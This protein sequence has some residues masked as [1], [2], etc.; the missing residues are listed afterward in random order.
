MHEHNTRPARLDGGLQIFAGLERWRGLR[1]LTHDHDTVGVRDGSRLA[2]DVGL[3]VLVN[4]LVPCA[5]L[6]AVAAAQIHLRGLAGWVLARFAPV[7]HDRDDRRDGSDHSRH[8]ANHSPGEGI[9]AVTIR[10]PPSKD[11][12]QRHNQANL[13]KAGSRVNQ[14]RWRLSFIRAIQTSSMPVMHLA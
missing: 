12:R 4:L 10:I 14:R 3:D 13:L 11:T 6:H 2:F 1:D 7:L 5:D 9:H 8:G